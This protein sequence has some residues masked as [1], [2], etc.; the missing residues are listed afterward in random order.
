MKISIRISGMML[1]VGIMFLGCRDKEKAIPIDPATIFP[2]GKVDRIVSQ[3]NVF[4][5]TGTIVT[6]KG[7]GFDANSKENY[8]LFIKHDFNKMRSI[9]SILYEDFQNMELLKESNPI[10]I[11]DSMMT[12]R[13]KKYALTM[14]AS[15][16]AYIYFTKVKKNDI[17]GKSVRATIFKR[18][19]L[20][21]IP[22]YQML[23]D[24]LLLS[25]NYSPLNK[26]IIKMG[27]RYES[28][29]ASIQNLEYSSKDGYYGLERDSYSYYFYTISM[30]ATQKL[31]YLPDG[32]YDFHIDERNGLQ[33]RF[34]EEKGKKRI[35]IKNEH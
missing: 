32:W 17:Q 26:E 1:T 20:E 24:T 29:K 8:F 13:L 5:D 33:R 12:F 27:Y 10:S 7:K 4:I 22:I 18:N 30:V 31:F 19:T 34:V 2:T 15:D 35:Y 9:D 6:I 21:N 28:I 11:N 16:S 3:S 25:K 14:S 23:N